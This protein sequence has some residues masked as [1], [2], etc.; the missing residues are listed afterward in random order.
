MPVAKYTDVSGIVVFFELLLNI[1]E[2]NLPI[3]SYA[4]D[5]PTAFPVSASDEAC[6]PPMRRPPAMGGSKEL[7]I[8]G[9]TYAEARTTARHTSS[10]TKTTLYSLIEQ[11]EM[12]VRGG[13]SCFAFGTS[14][15]SHFESW[16]INFVR[17]RY[18]PRWRYR[19]PPRR[20]PPSA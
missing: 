19:N 13:I 3:C 1:E 11:H 12:R 9:L 8:D 7:E 10:N 16:T 5:T 2:N 4:V 14:H 20:P 6:A 15:G 18:G 17:L